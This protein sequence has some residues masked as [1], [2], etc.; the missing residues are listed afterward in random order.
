LGMRPYHKAIVATVT[1]AAA[2]VYVTAD[3]PFLVVGVGDGTVGVVVEGFSML[4]PVE[5][6]PVE[7][8]F[9]VDP[10]AVVKGLIRSVSSLN[11]PT[12]QSPMLDDT[13]FSTSDLQLVD[14]QALA[15][16]SAEIEPGAGDS[17]SDSPESAVQS[18]T[19]GSASSDVSSVTLHG[20]CAE[21]V[22]AAVAA[23]MA[24]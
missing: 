11:V 20:A 13:S 24:K 4:F 8:E 18:G 14:A 17:D 23:R 7:L 10:H 22:A 5:L 3:A 6:V 16:I 2:T 1:M 9:S 19:F 21:T 12:E 15:S